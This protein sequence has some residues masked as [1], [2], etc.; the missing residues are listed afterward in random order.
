MWKYTGCSREFHGLVSAL[1][2]RTSDA[3]QHGSQRH[4][5]R[6]S[7]IWTQAATVWT[8]TGQMAALTRHSNKGY[9]CLVKPSVETHLY[10]ARHISW[11]DLTCIRAKLNIACSHTHAYNCFFLFLHFYASALF[12][13]SR[14]Y[15]FG[16]VLLRST[17]FTAKQHQPGFWCYHMLHRLDGGAYINRILFA[18]L[19]QA[20]VQ[21]CRNSS[22]LIIAAGCQ[23]KVIPLNTNNVCFSIKQII[24]QLTIQLMTKL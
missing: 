5:Q 16:S 10:T 15:I 12:A 3:V 6:T 19:A 18:F 20:T 9:Y 4:I 1:P 2:P 13:S 7:R 21:C 24:I 14:G 8:R 11:M 17:V 22:A 23:R